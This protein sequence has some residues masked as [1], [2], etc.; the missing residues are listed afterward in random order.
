V[1]KGPFAEPA[2]GGYYLLRAE[3]LDAAG[4]IAQ[5]CPIAP[6]ASLDVRPVKGGH[7]GLIDAADPRFA[8]LVDLA[9]ANVGS[10]L[11]ETSRR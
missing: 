4:E 2:L 11:A 6:G 7:G 9:S 1:E 5:Q 3:N 8:L 10:R